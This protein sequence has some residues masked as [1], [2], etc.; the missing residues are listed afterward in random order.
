[1]TKEDVLEYIRKQ[2]DRSAGFRQMIEDF[3]ADGPARRQLKE[4][5]GELVRDRQ[6]VRHRGNRFEAPRTL[7]LVHGRITIHP[8]GYGF[9]VL[10]ESVP[11]ISGDVF[12]P[13]HAVGSA[14][15]GDRVAVAI[16]AT[17]RAEGRVARVLER[18]RSTVVGQ[19]RYDGRTYFL[20]P[21][22]RKLPEKILVTGEVSEHKD[23]IIEVELSNFGSPSLWPSGKLISVIGF[24]DDPDVETT[25][26]MRKYGLEVEFPEEVEADAHAIPLEIDEDEIRTRTDFR[27]RETLTIDP[28]TA[29]DFDDAV[30]VVRLTDGGWELGV[31]IADV[32]HYVRPG[33]P[34]DREARQR[35]CSVYFPDRVVPMLPERLSN[36]ICSLNPHTDRL[37]MSAIMTVDSEGRVVGSRFANSVIRSR[38]R[39]DYGTVQK[40]LDGDGAVRKRHHKIVGAVEILGKLARI[41]RERRWERGTI[42]LDL[43]EPELSYDES[44]EVVGI[45]KA[46]RYAS[47]RLIEEFMIAANEAVARHL[48][49]EMPAT[50]F[51]VHDAPDPERVGDLGDT[52][53]ALGLRFHPKQVTPR[54]FQQFLE[55]IAGRP[56]E[57]MISFLVLRSFRQAVYSTINVGHFGLASRSYLHFT[58]PIRRY[59]DLVVHRILKARLTGSR[60]PGYVP[61]ELES[62]A[63]TSSARERIADMAERDLF[64]WKRMN[65]LEQHLGDTLEAVI[66]GVHRR[67]VR[68]ELVDYFIEGDL[69]VDDMDD[70][71]YE[72]D[73]QSR[74]LIGRGT[75]RRYRLGQTLKVR[76]ARI[77][78]LL[79]R[80][81]FVPDTEQGK[82]TR[83]RGSE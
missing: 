24:I 65:L 77:D 13:P 25:V 38:E 78:K 50:I 83:R 57:Q 30:D 68:L 18:A 73:P 72:F 37:A 66:I 33:S 1:M 62:I 6:L 2:D 27:D 35:G 51:R 43:P 11:G 41:M 80:A 79:G 81:Y 29:R 36:D 26:I 34:T 20:T 21:A 15:E 49:K 45:V 46:D 39:T 32:A 53:A 67:G 60:Q 4:I 59:P 48:E 17:E 8:D 19:L 54:A 22:D 56:D 40:I 64:D 82:R 71:F 61:G 52:L 10:E 3:D 28:A 16:V 63:R 5:L 23:K 14:M 47:H 9:V 76:V 31:H 42:D 69:A 75:R 44:G 7:P 55:S 70:D 12:I 74:S 58:S